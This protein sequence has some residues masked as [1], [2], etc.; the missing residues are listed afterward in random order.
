[1][2]PL[3]GHLGP[4]EGTSKCWS[5]AD[6]PL[7][8][9]VIRRWKGTTSPTTRERR[10]R[11]ARP[12]AGTRGH[13]SPGDEA[14]SLRKEWTR[15]PT[16]GRPEVPVLYPAG[17]SLRSAHRAWSGTRALAPSQPSESRD[18]EV[19]GAEGALGGGLLS[20][21]EVARALC[22]CLR[23]SAGACPSRASPPSPLR[24]VAWRASPSF[25]MIEFHESFQHWFSRPVSSLRRW[26][27]T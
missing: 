11:D 24:A 21:Y 8:V 22:V 10:V 9:I 13:V 4:R 3:G 12:P 7:Q 15:V 5:H 16:R 27:S 18:D 1:M 6:D 26:Y 17:A 2:H 20:V 25:Q 19:A 14:V 23:E